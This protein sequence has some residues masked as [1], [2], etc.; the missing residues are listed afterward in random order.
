[1]WEFLTPKGEKNTKT[2]PG[3]DDVDLSNLGPV[4]IDLVQH[5]RF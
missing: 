2:D 5:L 1:M 4:C 3:P